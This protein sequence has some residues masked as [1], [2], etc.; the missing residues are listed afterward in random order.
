MK[1]TI[2]VKEFNGN[3]KELAENVG[4]LYYDSLAD[5]LA[6]LAEKIKS[7]GD[8]DFGRGRKRLAQE[9]YSCSEHLKLASNHISE[10]WDICSPFVEKWLVDNGYDERV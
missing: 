10:A 6:L 1:H 9:L 3:N 2:N 5:F 7:D 4:D 8:A